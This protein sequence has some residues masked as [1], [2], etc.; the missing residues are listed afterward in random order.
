MG[1]DGSVERFGH[2][3]QAHGVVVTP[4]LGIRLAPV[5]YPGHLGVLHGHAGPSR[6]PP[7]R[8]PISPTVCEYWRPTGAGIAGIAPPDTKHELIGPAGQHDYQPLHCVRLKLD[9]TAAAT[10]DGGRST[11]VEAP[12]H[13]GL[14]APGAAE[15]CTVI[16]SR[17]DESATPR[18][19]FITSRSDLQAIYAIPAREAL[20][21]NLSKIDPQWQSIGD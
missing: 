11:V 15:R 5:A 17:A 20:A 2:R 19:R 7:R 16:R 6:H 14:S 13:L 8:F 1:S 4:D 18:P 12:E 9:S 10:K 3:D 21:C